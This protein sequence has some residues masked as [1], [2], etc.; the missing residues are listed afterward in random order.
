MKTRIKKVL[1][2]I[3]ALMQGHLSGRDFESVTRLSTLLARAQLLQ[4]RA[5]ELEGEVSEIEAT[6]K[7]LNGKATPQKVAEIIPQLAH[8]DDESED[9]GRTAPQT[10]RIEID[11]KA[12]CKVR[13]KE[14]IHLPKAG[15]GLVKFLS[16]LVEE[17]GKDALQ[18][19]SRIRINRGPLLSKTPAADF[20]NQAQGKLYGHKRL[21]GTD[22]FVLTHS[23][24]SQK[25]GDVKRICRV[26]GLAPGS[27]QVSAVSRNAY[28]EHETA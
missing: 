16:R 7:G 15:D 22:Y 2:D 3:G 14:V 23:P 5:T 8:H 9:F 19:L 17:L 26:L 21:L 10:L 13:E 6:I 24:T 28:Y 20:L 25:V 4:K 1:C 11:W 18:K 27:V 12:N